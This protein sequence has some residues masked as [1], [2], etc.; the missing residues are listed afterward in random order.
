MQKIAVPMAGRIEIRGQV[1]T[2][3]TREVFLGF[4]KASLLHQLSVADVLNEDTGTGYQRR[5]NSQ[6]SLDFR[7]YIK[8]SGSTTI[9][10]T[11]NLRPDG[12][13]NWALNRRTDGTAI[14]SFGPTS[15]RI[16]YQ[17][18]CQHRLGFLA[19]QDID[20]AFMTFIGLDAKEEMEI[21]SI[22]NGKAKGLSTSLLDYHEAQMASDLQHDRPELY[23]AL[24]LHEDTRSPWHK[25]LDLGGRSTSGLK[26][27]ASLRTMQKAV[28]RFLRQSEC[29]S[30]GSP[31][32]AYEFLRSFWKGV[33][34]VLEHEWNEPRKHFV[35]KGI[36]VLR[37]SR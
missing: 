14:L 32:L 17:V 31:H 33:S 16:M 21:F 28:K 35:T 34:I 29:L 25:Q 7:R 6:H 9:P 5:F 11:F 24:R 12:K 1:G 4:A 8:N 37:L 13:S 19:G 18:D 36:G 23:I 27:R 20:F 2:C 22:I 30:I 10:L 3:G 15:R 26:R